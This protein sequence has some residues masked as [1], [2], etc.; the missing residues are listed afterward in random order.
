VAEIQVR[1]LTYRYPD[2]NPALRDVSLCAG[3]GEI[4]GLVG[5]NGAGK[6]T[7]LL[8]LNGVLAANGAVAV[9]DVPVTPASLR[10]TRRRVGLVFQNPDDQLFMPRVFDDVAFG[11]INLGFPPAVV[12]R[13]V[14]EALAAVGMSHFAERAP[15]HL[16]LGE[17]KKIAI[18]TVLVMECEVLALDEPTAGL[19]PRAR[20]D[21]MRLLADLPCTQMIATHDLEMAVELF[22]RVALLSRGALVAEGEPEALLAD[23][24]LMEAHGLEVPHSLRP[25]LGEE[26]HRRLRLRSR[27]A[28]A[29]I[30]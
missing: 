2:G 21:L 17:K 27:V 26:H 8:H 5:A 9:G 14:R 29:S 13:K 23:E 12:E 4:V 6:S 22:D 24:A 28:K 10:E 16:S 7:L 30:G 15:Q 1:S 20:R 11:A 19:D 3:H 25:H 18:A